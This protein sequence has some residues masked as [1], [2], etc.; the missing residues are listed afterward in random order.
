M[1]MAMV[2]KEENIR[3]QKRE[4][5]FYGIRS[6]NMLMVGFSMLTDTNTL[7]VSP[8][9]LLFFRTINV[10]S[11]RTIHEDGGAFFPRATQLTF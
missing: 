2:E 6:K 10:K 3:I 5:S 4:F 8:P 1:K 7:T 11:V 9:H